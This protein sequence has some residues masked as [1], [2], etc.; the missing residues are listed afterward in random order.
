M[1]AISTLRSTGTLA[2]QCEYLIFVSLRT[3]FEGVSQSI[4]KKLEI[5]YKAEHTHE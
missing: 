5:Q 4:R 2:I 3:I 1:A